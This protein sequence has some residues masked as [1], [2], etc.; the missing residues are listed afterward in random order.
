MAQ[1]FRPASNKQ[2][3]DFVLNGEELAPIKIFRDFDDIKD[4]NLNND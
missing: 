3:D 1:L 4:D 2:D